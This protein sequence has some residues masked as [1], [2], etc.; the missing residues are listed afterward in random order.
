[1]S[2]LTITMTF[3]SV[4]KKTAIN[5]AGGDNLVITGTYFPPVLDPRYQLTIMLGTLTQCIPSAITTT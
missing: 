2:A 3:V 4:N 5:P 1:M